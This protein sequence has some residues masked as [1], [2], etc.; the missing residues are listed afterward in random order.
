VENIKDSLKS[1]TNNGTVREQLSAFMIRRRI[2]LKVGTA[3][4]KV[5]EEI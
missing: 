4:K 5:V 3:S 1:D 2:I